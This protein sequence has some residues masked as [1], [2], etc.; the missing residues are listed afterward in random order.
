MIMR[1]WRGAV[2][3]EDA[4]QYLEHQADTGVRE[5]RETAGPIQ[6]PASVPLVAI[7]R[8]VHRYGGPLVASV[9]SGC[10]W[11]LSAPTVDG[12]TVEGRRRVADADGS[13][14]GWRK[15]T[16]IPGRAGLALAA[17]RRKAPVSL[18]LTTYAESSSDGETRRAV[19]G[20]DPRPDTPSAHGPSLRR[21]RPP[22]SG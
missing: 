3:T 13:R 8:P 17:V 5:Y 19:A 18:V 12:C 11:P 1:T 21:S 2:K 7:V 22:V 15:L 16:V 10:Q 9:T 6:R 14:R 20:A 4:D